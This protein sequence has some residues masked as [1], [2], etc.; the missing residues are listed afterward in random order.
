VAV[1]WGKLLAFLAVLALAQ[2]GC[3][4]EWGE[5]RFPLGRWLAVKR[6]CLGR[7]CHARTRLDLR[8]ICEAGGSSWKVVFHQRFLD[9]AL[10]GPDESSGPECGSPCC[11]LAGDGC[12]PLRCA[13]VL[14]FAPACKSSAPH[15]AESELPSARAGLRAVR[16]GLGARCSDSER[17]GSKSERA[18]SKSE[19]GG[20]ESESGRIR[21][22][23]GGGR[24]GKSP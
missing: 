22:G 19:R 14:V 17:V 13:E 21:V 18:G 7:R 10:R 23:I 3:V 16:G 5:Q 9:R 11:R 1:I 8:G 12:S 4:T 20:S 15:L 24:E 6:V 2:V